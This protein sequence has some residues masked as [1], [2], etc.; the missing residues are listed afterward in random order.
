M[1][2]P[3]TSEECHLATLVRSHIENLNPL[4]QSSLA[5]AMMS[6]PAALA[7]QLENLAANSPALRPAALRARSLANACR[8]PAKIARLLELCQ[9][10]RSSRPDWRVVVFTQRAET[11]K[12]I[13]ERLALDGIPVGYIRG[14]RATENQKAIEGFRAD[15]PRIRALVST[16]AGAEGINL[17]AGNVLVNY[18]LPWN[19]MVVEQ[20]IG[21]IQ[22]LN[23]RH[24]RV[25]ILN[26]VA[27]GTVEEHVV[28]R[29][30]E[31]LQSV[32]ESVGDIESILE[33]TDGGGDEPR[34]ENVIRDLV[35]RSLLGQNVELAR[36]QEL[37]SIERA[38][39]LMAEQRGE[40][41]RTL[42][43]LEQLHVSG[44]QM[45]RLD[46]AV[47]TVSARDFVLRAKRADGATVRETVPGVFA[48]EVAGRETEK[49][50][51]DE[52]AA[53]SHASRA[54][55]MG[56]V[57]LYSPGK[58]DFERL[59]QHWVDRCGH[60]LRDARPREEAAVA[61]LATA[62]CE[63]VDGATMIGYGVLDRKPHFRG[64]VVVRAKAVNGVDSFEKLVAVDF[65]EDG[66]DAIP[67]EPDTADPV[68]DEAV[69]NDYL[70]GRVGALSRAV[71]TDADIGEFHRFYRERLAEESARTGGDSRLNRKV[72]NDFAVAIHADAVGIEGVRYD[73][74]RLRIRYRVDGKGEYA[75]VLSAVP[76]SG[77]IV[78]EPPRSACERTGRRV[79]TDCLKRC[80]ITGLNALGHLLETSSSGRRVLR[81][82]IVTCELSGKRFADDEVGRSAVSGTV[83]ARSAFVECTRTGELLLPE[84]TGTSDASGSVVRKDLL[85]ASDKPPHRLGLPD[86]FETCAAT[87]RRLLQDELESSV[88][89]ASR[90]DR[91]LLRPSAKSGRLALSHELVIC[92]ES[93]AVLLPDETAPCGLTGRRV[94]AA[95]L[96]PSDVSGTRVLASRLVACPVTKKWLLPAEFERCAVTGIE[97]IP[98]ALETCSTTGV[99]ALRTE[100]VRCEGSGV[101]V[102]RSEAGTSAYS[103]K[104]VSRRLLVRSDIP[105]HRWGLAEETATCDVTGRVG[106]LDELARSDRSGRLVDRE[107]LRKSAASNSWALPDEMVAC[108]ESGVE[109]LPGEAI[110]CAVT[111]KPVDRRLASPSEVSGRIGLTR[112]LERCAATGTLALPDELTACEVGGD[113]VLPGE[114]DHCSVTGRRVLRSRL[115][116]CEKSGSLALETEVARS[117]L[118]RRLVLKSLLVRSELPPHRSGLAEETAKCEVT[119]RRLLRDEVV[120]SAVSGRRAGLDRLAPSHASGRLALAEELATCEETGARLLPGEMARCSESGKAVDRRRL[121]M[122]DLTGRPVLARLAGRCGVT[123]KRVLL[124]ELEACGLTGKSVLPTELVTCAITGTR[125]LRGS[126]ARSDLSGRYAIPAESFRSPVCGLTGLSD[127]GARCSWLQ[128][129]AFKSELGR[130]ALT[131]RFVAKVHLNADGQLAPLA[132]LLDGR[133]IDGSDDREWIPILRKLDGVFADLKRVESVRSPGGVI[134]VCCEIRTR[135]W[136]GERVKYIGALLRPGERPKLLNNGVHGYRGGDS[137]FVIEDVRAF[138]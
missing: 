84:E 128:E 31:K 62:W 95:L 28:G 110:K 120:V 114:L 99:R 77:Q 127:E 91:E 71:E 68:A 93:G 136:L 126:M 52:A 11:Q 63:S 37:E 19:P 82:R 118:S 129:R 61:R 131:G 74:V 79:P 16:D 48:V 111:R 98:N 105:P 123:G 106:L 75:T 44:P 132:D 101:W 38:R 73:E 102:L 21:R 53:D 59:V 119:G 50:T 70:P 92:D 36:Q 5:Q 65:G 88:V 58:R 124:R 112:L 122:H 7:A 138:G 27:A 135:G 121:A 117:D 10:L 39:K 29:L 133:S 76:A 30:V 45:P 80:A 33:T 18:D 40:L 78:E 26:L 55:F 115:V 60:L 69:P 32:A 64:R 57:R 13:G 83:A 49:F 67:S 23:S 86:E 90:V 66:H 34:F 1:K 2:V 42:G 47:P 113:R 56:S 94:D 43:G 125:G 109:L 14:G 17:Q 8:E 6:S 15:P 22:R 54:V 103:E 41:D 116:A 24:E 137:E 85:A 100:M 4:V 3:L 81:D 107:L 134:A 12:A 89:S 96:R 20:R 46:R 72:Q 9:E 35:V 108:S 25:V 51:F 130:C 97:V 87:G 104:T